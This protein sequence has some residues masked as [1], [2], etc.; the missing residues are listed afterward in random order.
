EGPG[1]L[2]RQLKHERKSASLLR[3]C[4]CACYY[5]QARVPGP[6]GDVQSLAQRRD[7]HVGH[8]TLRP[9]PATERAKL[10]SKPLEA[11]R[12]SCHAGRVNVAKQ[13]HA[14]SH[15]VISLLF[16]L[17]QS[18]YF[19]LAVHAFAGASELDVVNL[20]EVLIIAEHPVFDHPVGTSYNDIVFNYS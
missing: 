17:Q 9:E 18:P 3:N 20:L 15:F 8:Y 1:W 10:T 6:R 19:G 16:G 14:D 13:V 7:A 11:F 4:S 5:Y 12:R 2:C